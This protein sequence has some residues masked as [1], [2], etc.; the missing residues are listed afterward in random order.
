L[1]NANSPTSAG[2][3]WQ[4]EDA[5]EKLRHGLFYLKTSSPEHDLMILFGTIKTILLG[6]GA[7]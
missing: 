1:G 5:T 3:G 6:P 7:K 2:L 4:V